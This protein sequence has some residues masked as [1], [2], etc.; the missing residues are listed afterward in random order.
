MKFASIYSI[1]LSSSLL[2]EMLFIFFS[3]TVVFIGAFILDVIG[4]FDLYTIGCGP[5]LN[6]FWFVV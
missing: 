6:L 2:P 4:G 1:L 5:V 3:V